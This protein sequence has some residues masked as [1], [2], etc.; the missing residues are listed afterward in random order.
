MVPALVVGAPAFSTRAR[1]ESVPCQNSESMTPEATPKDLEALLNQRERISPFWNEQSSGA[2]C[3]LCSL[4]PPIAASVPSK[5]KGLTSR[6][7]QGG[8]R[9]NHRPEVSLGLHEEGKP[10]AGRRDCLEL[11]GGEGC[12]GDSA[13]VGNPG[14]TSP[15]P[16]SRARPARA[17]RL[18]AH[19][20]YA[21]HAAEQDFCAGVKDHKRRRSFRLS[22]EPSMGSAGGLWVLEPC[23][24]GMYRGWVLDNWSLPVTQCMKSAASVPTCSRFLK[25][26]NGLRFIL[27]YCPGKDAL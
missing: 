22:S 11:R 15:T 8:P 16:T 5:P 12:E 19:A 4:L 13:A 10:E 14:N 21:P 17:N 24:A 3:R 9:K 25:E 20:L 26:R 1:Q 23:D 7:P 18:V 6:D 27:R 2:E